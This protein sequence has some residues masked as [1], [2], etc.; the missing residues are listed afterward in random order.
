MNRETWSRSGRKQTP[1]KPQNAKR[2]D[3]VSVSKTPVKKGGKKSVEKKPRKEESSPSP[4]ESRG[5]KGKASKIQPEPPKKGRKASK[6]IE[7]AETPKK[8]KT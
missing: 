2:K 5:R 3:A 6:S 7:K 1:E 8:G 4:A